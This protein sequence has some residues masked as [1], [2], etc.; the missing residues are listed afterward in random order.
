MTTDT[1]T[2]YIS[3]FGS[4]FWHYGFDF[5]R[6]HHPAIVYIDG[7]QE[8]YKHG[9]RHRTDGPAVEWSEGTKFWY[10]NGKRHRTDGPAIEYSNGTKR[11]YLDD[12]ELTE[13]QFNKTKNT[14]ENKIVEID[15]KKY[16]LNLIK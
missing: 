1:I 16:T 3:Q 10:H 13:E 9:K 5:D 15:G 8:W 4:K 7:Q 2:L 11:W 6:A 12:K 14:C